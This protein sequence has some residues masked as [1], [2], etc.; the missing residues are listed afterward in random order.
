MKSNNLSLETSINEL[1]F[2]NKAVIIRWNAWKKK[3]TTKNKKQEKQQ[4]QKKTYTWSSQCQ[5]T[6]SVIMIIIILIII[7]IIIIIIMISINYNKEKQKICKTIRSNLS[8]KNFWHCWYK[9]NY[10]RTSK[11][12]I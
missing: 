5:W 1:D 7:I 2:W 11:N 10:Y 8:T 4:Q 9:I 6:L 12:F 3:T